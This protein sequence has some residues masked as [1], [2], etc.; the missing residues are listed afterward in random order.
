MAIITISRGTLS[1]GQRL[2]RCA[3]TNLGYRIISREELVQEA[4]R[5]YG[6]TEAELLRGLEQAPG[7]WDRF[8]T[9]RHIYLSVARATLCH[10]VRDDYVVYHGYAGHLLLRDVGYV[11][12][13]RIIAPMRDRIRAAR[14]EHGFGEGAA[15][16]YI[17]KRDEERV[18]WT[19]FLYGIE[20]GDPGLYD[21]TLNLEKTSIETAC[22]VLAALV[23]RPEFKVTGENRRQLADLELAA[24]THAKLFLNPKVGAAAAKLEIKAKDGVVSLHGILPGDSLVED[25]IAACRQMPEIHEV[26]ADWLDSRVERV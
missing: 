4:S 9:D 19:R 15:E 23:D 22:G 24:H 14:E 26:Q 7:F 11:L 8:R 10:L 17:R 18:S 3:G 16:A 20:W 1:G 12:R 25:V 6:V 21:L 13:V 5:R 2:A